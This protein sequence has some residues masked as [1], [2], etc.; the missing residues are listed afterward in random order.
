M[1]P[2]VDDVS[3]GGFFVLS[4]ALNEFSKDS[5]CHSE[6]SEE[7]RFECLKINSAKNPAVPTS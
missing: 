4:R 3:T 7:S 5:N 1:K 2:P 6:R